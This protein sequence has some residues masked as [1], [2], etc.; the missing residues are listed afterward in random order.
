MEME[1]CK[2]CGA[3]GSWQQDTITLGFSGQILDLSAKPVVAG[4]DNGGYFSRVP[5]LLQR[6]F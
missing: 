6:I 5:T 1:C 3:T 4:L 2:L